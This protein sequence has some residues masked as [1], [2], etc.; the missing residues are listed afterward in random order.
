MGKCHRKG[1]DNDIYFVARHS[2]K[3][4]PNEGGLGEALMPS[5]YDHPQFDEFFERLQRW[6]LQSSRLGDT[7][8]FHSDIS[9]VSFFKGEQP[10]RNTPFF[11]SLVFVV[12]VVV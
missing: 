8:C 1:G 11:Y 2:N 6:S 5:F 4:S 9:N 10:L 12:V 3:N 7:Q